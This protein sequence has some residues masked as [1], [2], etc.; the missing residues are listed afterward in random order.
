MSRPTLSLDDGYEDTS[1]DLKDEVKE[2]QT[3][4]NKQGFSVMA[5]GLFGSGTEQA[6]RKFQAAHGLHVDGVVGQATWTA[7]LGA[8]STAVAQPSIV[9]SPPPVS[10]S[11]PAPPPAAAA[12]TGGIVFPTTFLPNDP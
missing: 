10:P 4:L 2:F 5:D 8:Q 9:S 6:V 3:L 7:L 12:A 1:P 11:P